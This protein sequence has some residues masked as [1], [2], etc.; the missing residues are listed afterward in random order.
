MKK[1]HWAAQRHLLAVVSKTHCDMTHGILVG[2]QKGNVS[3]YAGWMAGSLGSDGAS[4]GLRLGFRYEEWRAPRCLQIEG[5]PVPFV[6]LG[7]TVA[8]VK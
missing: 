4:Q 6:A 1:S 7:C 8:Q 3:A 5:P 2:I